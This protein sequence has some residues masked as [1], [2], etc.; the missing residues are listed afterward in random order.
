MSHYVNKY[1]NGWDD[2]VDYALM[3]H[4]STPHSITKSS[5]YYLLHGRDMRMPNIEDLTAR[6]G[7]P[8]K[9]PEDQDRVSSHIRTLY[10]KTRRVIRRGS[11]AEQNW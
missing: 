9:E 4:R 8:K 1:G 6:M 10:G 11:K 2:F 5:P 7:V 3:V